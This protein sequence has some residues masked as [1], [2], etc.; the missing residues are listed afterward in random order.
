MAN[1]DRMVD[2]SLQIDPLLPSNLY[3]AEELRDFDENDKVILQSAADMEQFVA[4]VA[5]QPVAIRDLIL[6]ILDKGEEMKNLG[7]ERPAPIATSDIE[8]VGKT[9]ISRP[10]LFRW[11][12]HL[13]AAGLLSMI[14]PD[15]DDDDSRYFFRLVNS[16]PQSGDW[17]IFNTLKEI[18]EK[19]PKKRREVLVRAI[20]ELDFTMFEGS[21]HDGG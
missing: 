10:E 14:E 3:G 9:N 11:A 8:I 17:N 16:G 4:N 7:S 1:L 15:E 13:R 12:H 20:I 18:A 19:D 5:K 21:R 6:F 2:T